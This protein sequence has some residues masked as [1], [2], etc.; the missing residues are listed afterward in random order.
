VV[1]ASTSVRRLAEELGVTV[2]LARFH[3]HRGSAP[4]MLFV[5]LAAPVSFAASI[6]RACGEQP[7]KV[8]NAVAG[9]ASTAGTNVPA[10]RHA[11]SIEHSGRHDEAIVQARPLLG[12]LRGIG[13]ER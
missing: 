5:A 8:P 4:I 2:N 3:A 1:D 7:S 11:V 10:L 12:A 13:V 9:S 6:E